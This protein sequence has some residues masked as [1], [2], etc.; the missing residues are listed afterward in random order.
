MSQFGG[1]MGA[2]SICS[3]FT[4]LLSPAL[5]EMLCDVNVGRYQWLFCLLGGTP[6]PAWG[7]GIV[8]MELT[9]YTARGHWQPCPHCVNTTVP[10]ISR[11]LSQSE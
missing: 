11:S 7:G 2:D 9:I 4:G 3:V 1:G 5:L 10:L 8:K 6:E